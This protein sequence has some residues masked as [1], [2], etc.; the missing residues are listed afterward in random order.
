[1]V[2]TKYHNFKLI[3]LDIMCMLMRMTWDEKIQ[4]KIES[5]T[6]EASKGRSRKKHNRKES[7]YLSF[8]CSAPPPDGYS[9]FSSLAVVALSVPFVLCLPLCHHVWLL[10]LFIL[11]TLSFHYSHAMHFHAYN[12]L[13]IISILYTLFLHK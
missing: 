4:N 12:C 11:N 10:Q 5:I 7:H 3:N 6:A 9:S 13:Y 2:L 1:M 8:F